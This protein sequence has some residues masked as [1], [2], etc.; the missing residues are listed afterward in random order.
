MHPALLCLEPRLNLSTIMVTSAVDSMN[1]GS[2]RWA[3]DQ[4]DMV[5]G[6]T[7]FFDPIRF[8]KPTTI[9]LDPNLG[10]LDLTASMT[11]LGPA[12]RLTVDAHKLSRVF[13]V[14]NG[15]TVTI[16]SLSLVGGKPSPS[17]GPSDPAEFDAD[18]GGGIEVDSGATLEL[19]H[20]T[21]SRCAAE[22]GGAIYSKGSTSLYD[23]TIRNNDA[24]QDYA[25]GVLENGSDIHLAGCTL[26]RNTAPSSGAFNVYHGSG[27]VVDCT[28]S[29]NTATSPSPGLYG[30]GAMTLNLTDGTVTLANCTITKNTSAR[31]G[32]AISVHAGSVNLES[33]NISGNRAATSGGAVSVGSG[34]VT[35]FG[36]VLSHN[37][38]GTSKGGVDVEGGSLV[39]YATKLSHNSAGKTRGELSVSGKFTA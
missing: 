13:E 24:S 21:I 15:A 22:A 31:I 23:C 28:I 20:S 5:P 33:C 36:S 29:G 12:A 19:D 17:A 39:L 35:V 8:S 4:A 3:V 27:T 18:F 6:S 10:Q 38:A 1:P 30:G 26:T 11:I 16:S 25:G 32:G 14:E 7:I 2:L 37:K 34:T 9:A